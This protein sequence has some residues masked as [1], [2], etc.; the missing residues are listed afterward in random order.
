[1]SCS[2]AWLP[3]WEKLRILYA[4][5]DCILTCS[6]STGILPTLL[7]FLSVEDCPKLEFVARTLPA[8]LTYIHVELCPRLELVAETFLENT[9]LESITIKN[10]INFRSLPENM[11]LLTHL[12]L[13]E[14]PNFLLFPRLP[15]NKLKELI[16]SGCQNLQALPNNI[17]NITSLKVTKLVVAELLYQEY[18]DPKSPVNTYI[19]TQRDDIDGETVSRTSC[20]KYLPC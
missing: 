18:E 2:E 4:A 17:A 5:E 14:C 8:T 12:K 19:G 1:M 15:D 9:K 11:H 3:A 13:V 16:I 7:T 10:C 6:S 20:F